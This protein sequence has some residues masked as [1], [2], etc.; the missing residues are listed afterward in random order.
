M[1]AVSAGS[2]G[3][4][5]SPASVLCKVVAPNSLFFLFFFSFLDWT[6][7]TDY[8][9]TGPVKD[10]LINGA[11]PDTYF[12][13]FLEALCCFGFEEVYTKAARSNTVVQGS[14]R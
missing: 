7:F 5:R 2:E 6:G 13:L 14:F 1:E 11:G 3:S 8:V 10:Q 4:A 12:W 9:V